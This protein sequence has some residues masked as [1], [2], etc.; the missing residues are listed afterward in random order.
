MMLGSLRSL[1]ALVL[2]ARSAGQQLVAQLLSLLLGQE[3]QL[4]VGAPRTGDLDVEPRQPEHPGQQR[5]H[6]VDR[7]DAVELGPPVL[8]EQHPALDLQALAGQPE[9]GHPPGQGGHPRSD[10]QD[11]QGQPPTGQPGPA[12]QLG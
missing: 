9:P 10:Q 2:Q 8:A 7:L 12:A 5:L 3:G 4:E 1:L 11:Q 6:H